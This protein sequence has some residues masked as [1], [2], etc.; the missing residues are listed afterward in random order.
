MPIHRVKLPDGRMGYKWGA[1]GH[2]YPNR[3]GAEKQA[4][5]AH[6]HGYTGD[7]L[8]TGAGVCLTTPDG[9]MLFVRDANRDTWCFPGGTSELGETAEETA[10]RELE[11]ETTIAH[12]GELEP[13]NRHIFNGVDYTT[14]KSAV[15]NEIEPTLDAENTDYVWAGMDELPEPLHPAIKE[16]LKPVIA[17]DAA[18]AMDKSAR[19]FDRDGRLHVELTNI[20]KANICPYRGSEIPGWE[21]MGLDPEK[22]YNLYRD[23]EE[24]KKAQDTF[25]NVPLLSEHVPVNGKDYRPDLVIGSTGTDA[26]F[27]A[28]Y[29][30]NS[31]VVWADKAIKGIESERKKELSSA[32]YYTPDMTPGEVDG[33]PYDGVMRDI[34]A[35]HVALV[36]EGRA[37]PDVVVGDSKLEI[38]PMPRVNKGRKEKAREAI[39]AYMRPKLAADAT[40]DDINLLLE[41]LEESEPLMDNELEPNAGIP[42]V[43]AEDEEEYAAPAVDPV[44]QVKELI[45]AHCP[46]DVVAKIEELMSGNAADEDM[47]EVG[48]TA[49]DEEVEEKPFDK[50]AM[51]AAMRATEQATIK[52]MNAVREAERAVK[53]YVGELAMSFDS[54]EGVY[55]KA[56][57]IMGVGEAK[58]IHASALPAIL[59]MQPKPSATPAVALDSANPKGF[60]DRWGHLKIK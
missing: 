53:P 27:E 58:T 36:V 19:S 2:V 7:N 1:H 10:K 52:R 48:E 47:P 3:E 9:K 50:A 18:L 6:A 17:G 14:F 42:P 32:Y 22:V 31:L 55:R 25:N 37:G 8:V 57:E 29:L 60:A 30:K 51:D 15:N 44:A 16:Y 39:M 13:F 56:L 28:P 59:K 34:V 4:E 46:P 24:L 23:P 11:E 54:A 35:N 41:Q 12:D 38:N 49:L 26:I 43:K 21:E 40:I 20:S 33:Q 45:A 5:A